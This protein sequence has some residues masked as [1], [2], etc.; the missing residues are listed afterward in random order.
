MTILHRTLLAAALVASAAPAWAQAPAPPDDTPSIA[1]GATIFYDYTVTRQP[2]SK[3]ADGN[4]FTPSAFNLTRSYLN[5]TGNVSH[6][7]SFRVTP[8]ITRDTDAGSSLGGNLVARIKYAYAQ[9]NL[10]EWTGQ[11]RNTWVRAGVQQTPYLDYVESIYRY[12]FQGTLLA[13]R[14]AAEGSPYLTSADTGVSFHTTLPG[15]FGD[16]HAGV[17]NGEGYTRPEANDQKAFQVRATIRPIAL[18]SGVVGGRSL[19][20]TI[21]YDRDHYQQSAQRSRLLASLTVEH[22][23]VNGGFEYFNGTDQPSRFRSAV[24]S[25]GWSFWI[26]P[27]VK[28]RGNGLEGLFRVDRFKPDDRLPNQ[29]KQRVVGGVAYWFPHPGGSPTAALLVDVERVTFA[30]FPATPANA[31]QERISLH[32]LINF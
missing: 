24:E 1:V 11:W 10:S 2:R 17:Y 31:R 3:D 12:R 6:L 32:G 25:Q 20:V 22:R 16:F 5:I 13:E 23:R 30:G 9:I 21:F 7:V 27:F 4:T 8:D 14:E 28:E 18:S 15:N 19:G 26:T 29:E